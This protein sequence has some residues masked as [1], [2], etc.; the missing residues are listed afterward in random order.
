M[1]DICQ[2]PFVNPLGD[3]P[4]LLIHRRSSVE[5]AD[6][7][8]HLPFAAERRQ[9]QP[10]CSDLR[11]A[12]R[13]MIVGAH[14]WREGSQAVLHRPA[15]E[16]ERHLAVPL[17]AL[18]GGALAGIEELQRQGPRAPADQPS[19]LVAHSDQAVAHDLGPQ[20]QLLSHSQPA[21]DVARLLGR[22][23]VGAVGRSQL[24]LLAELQSCEVL[25]P[26]A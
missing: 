18:V 2:C 20:L 3:V 1:V 9:L 4:R 15:D 10:R 26:F 8:Q 6:A 11:C 19:A 16:Q 22:V 23:L 24:C 13:S 5:V 12:G 7:V 25:K 14:G 21:P 17:G